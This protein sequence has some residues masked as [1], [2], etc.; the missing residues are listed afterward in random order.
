MLDRSSTSV[1]GNVVVYFSPLLL[2]SGIRRVNY[3][4]VTWWFE[5]NLAFEQKV[6]GVQP[7][8]RVLRNFLMNLILLFLGLCLL[9]L[10]LV[11]VQLLEHFGKFL[12]LR[13]VNV[14]WSGGLAILF[15]F[16]F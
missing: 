3:W 10:R 5:F 13:L 14:L 15:L 7:L 6:L 1:D 2:H 9:V 4:A 8:L 11:G 16:V 12:D